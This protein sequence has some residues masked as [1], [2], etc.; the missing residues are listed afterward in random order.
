[1]RGDGGSHTSRR[2]DPHRQTQHR[3]PPVQNAHARRHAE[4][5]RAAHDLLRAGAGARPQHGQGQR[6]RGAGEVRERAGE[7]VEALGLEGDGGEG[8]GGLEAVGEGDGGGERAQEGRAV[9]GQA[10]EGGCQGHDG[11]WTG[12]LRCGLG[13]VKDVVF[14]NYCGRGGLEAV[15]VRIR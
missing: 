11:R 13:T 7:V 3:L 14:W 6:Q 8:D 10:E 9:G 1:M 15:L 2:P 12:G 4:G 5:R